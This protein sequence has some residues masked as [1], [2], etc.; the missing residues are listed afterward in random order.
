MATPDTLERWLLF[1]PSSLLAQELNRKTT[2]LLIADALACFLLVFILSDLVRRYH[3]KKRYEE[4]LLPLPPCPPKRGP[5]GH[6]GI[7][8]KEFEYLTYERWAKEQGER[9]S[10][11]VR[12]SC[13][14]G[15]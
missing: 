3:A 4:S 2:V 1:R 10:R 8:P 15:D 7:M 12:R 14:L 6:I 11:S 5:L 9:A 13:A